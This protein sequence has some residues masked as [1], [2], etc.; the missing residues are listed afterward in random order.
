[1]AISGRVIP[2]GY[3]LLPEKKI[4][5]DYGHCIKAEL[6]INRTEVWVEIIN[7]DPPHVHIT[8][9][10]QSGLETFVYGEPAEALLQKAITL[11]PPERVVE[12]FANLAR[13]KL[14]ADE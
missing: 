3:L 6:R 8:I 11:L 1:M 7:R 9:A 13:N 2:C 4:T 14:L 5:Y 10:N 12:I